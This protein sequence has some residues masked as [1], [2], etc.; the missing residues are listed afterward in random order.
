MKICVTGASSGIGRELVKQL[1][2]DG[3]TVWGI[4]RRENLLNDLK[5]Q[6]GDQ[7][8]YTACD[9]SDQNEVLKISQG[10]GKIEFFPEV[11]ILAAGA[12]LNDINPELNYEIFK[13]A[14]DVNLYGSLNFVNVFLPKFLQRNS[15]QFIAISSITA[16]K[17]SLRGIGYPASKAA[18]GIAFRGLDLAYRKKKIIFSTVYLGPVAT[19]MWNAKKSFAVVNKEQIA[20][21]IKKVM[22][23]KKSVYYIPFWPTLISRLSFLPDHWYIALT[24]LFR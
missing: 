12:F 22:K 24:E 8:F 17:P 16:L 10:M 4:A 9:V 18:L 19:E 20:L 15:G 23:T 5:K 6:L 7:F 1:V 11:I 2:K 14:M 3:H 21:A 13:K